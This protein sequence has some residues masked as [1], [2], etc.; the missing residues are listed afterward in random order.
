[1]TKIEEL[2]KQQAEI[3]QQINA[4]PPTAEG[5]YSVIDGIIDIEKYVNAKPKML[6][7]LKEANYGGENH[8]H[9]N[10]LAYY[11]TA[12]EAE[13][14]KSPTTKRVMLV[15]QRILSNLAPLDAFQSI[16]YINIKKIPGG[17]EANNDEIQNAYN[18]HKDL[19]LEQIEAYKPNIIIG[20]STLHYF[21]KDLPFRE[22]Q[23]MPMANMSGYNYFCGKDRLYISA[24][25]PAYWQGGM[26]DEMYRDSIYAA[27]S[28]WKSRKE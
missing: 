17:S 12:T 15:S 14:K 25:H 9:G 28:D 26:T 22:L 19:L 16:A 1:M 21:A 5:N 27:F 13:I 18:N 3:A 8:E 24:Y 20:G 2:K 4:I 10:L 6:W 11:R 7:I 23:P